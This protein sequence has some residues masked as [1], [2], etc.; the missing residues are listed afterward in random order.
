MQIKRNRLIKLIAILCI[1]VP[2]LYLIVSGFDHD[3]LKE[4]AV[5]RVLKTGLR[6]VIILC[7]A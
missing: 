2:L 5:N 3:L 1:T 6:Q 4:S 7:I